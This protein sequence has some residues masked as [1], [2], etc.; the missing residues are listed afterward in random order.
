M[1]PA[2]QLSKQGFARPW[3]SRTTTTSWWSSKLA[4]SEHAL[5]FA[6]A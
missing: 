2:L 6:K 3:A 5:W 4:S 1:R